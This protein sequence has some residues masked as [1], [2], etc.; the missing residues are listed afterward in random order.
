MV[1]ELVGRV[2][3]RESASASARPLLIVVI[4]C[5]CAGTSKRDE[6]LPSSSFTSQPSFNAAF[7]RSDGSCGELYVLDGAIRVEHHLSTRLVTRTVIANLRNTYAID[8][9][10]RTIEVA[11]PVAELPLTLSFLDHERLR[12]CAPVSG[13]ELP[14]ASRHD[15]VC[16]LRIGGERVVMGFAATQTTIMLPARDRWSVFSQA[17]QL[18]IKPSWF[19]LDVSAPILGRYSVTEV[20][21]PSV[22]SD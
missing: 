17:R 22:W 14:A 19:E 6:S 11:P 2:R 20:D 3:A 10:D 13:S 18:R 15:H 16:E 1:G 7:L 4:T 12:T 5:S 21:Q 9:R 8:H